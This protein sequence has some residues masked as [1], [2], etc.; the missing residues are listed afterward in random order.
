MYDKI[1]VVVT[2]SVNP[3]YNIS[4]EARLLDVCDEKTVFMYLWK[5]DNTVVIGKNQ[6]A[7]KECDI[8]KLESE[9]GHLVRR[10]TGGGAVYHDVKNVNFSFYAHKDNYDVVKQ[11][12]VILLAVKKL[13]INAER[14]GRN[15]ITVDGRKFSGNSFL[16]KGEIKLHNGTILVDTDTEKM[17]KFLTVSLDKMKSKGVDSVRSRVVNLKEL[18]PGLTTERLQEKLLESFDEVYGL[19]A[20]IVCEKDLGL[21]EVDTIRKERF[22]NDEWRFGTNPAFANVL[23]KR[24]DWGSAEIRYSS[25]KG[26]ITEIKIFS[27]ALDAEEIERVEGALNKKEIK[28]L[29]ETAKNEGTIYKDIVSLF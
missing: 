2:E 27:D 29:N 26:V 17:T 9:S 15:D 16:T 24:F 14:S 10:M 6:N 7:F 5:N 23:E 22:E 28:A 11:A 20:E 3:F 19:K 12:Q 25:A 4:L 18:C 21:A 13:G 8:K 1:K